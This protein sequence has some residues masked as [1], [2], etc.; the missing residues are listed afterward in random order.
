MFGESLSQRLQSLSYILSV[1]FLELYDIHS[2]LDCAVG[3]PMCIV[4]FRG[5]PASE[6]LI[7]E[8]WRK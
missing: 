7:C 4:H 3:L 8:D 1:A 6:V 5:S 2:V